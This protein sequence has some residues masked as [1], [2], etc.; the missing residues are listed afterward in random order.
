MKNLRTLEKDGLLKSKSYGLGQEGKHKFWSLARH[1]VIREF[2]LTPPKSEVHALKY[3]H[4]KMCADIFVALMNSGKLWAWLGEGNQ[5][6]GFR[7]DRGFK[8]DGRVFY[9]EAET[10]SQSED[11]WR[12]K[13]A[14]YRKHYH[15]THEPFNVLFIV[16]TEKLLERVARIFEELK[17]DDHYLVAV[18][19]EFLQDPFTAQLTSRN[20]TFSLSN[21]GSNHGQTE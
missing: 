14:N 9:L 4:E 16:P 17:T 19:D 15:S 10:G 5:K 18:L 3:D 8:V 20:D 12:G 13:I 1:P 11:K 7:Y 6:I 2:D 21:S